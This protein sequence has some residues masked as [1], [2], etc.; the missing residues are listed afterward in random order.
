MTKYVAQKGEAGSAYWKEQAAI[1]NREFVDKLGKDTPVASITKADIRNLIERKA[2][3]LPGAARNLFAAIRPFFKW[4]V[5]RD[6][7]MV[8]SPVAALATPRAPKARDRILTDA[9]VIAFW[10]A[11]VEIGTLVGDHPLSTP[12]PIFTPFYQLLLLTAQRREEVAG[13]RWSE[14]DL[15]EATWTLP[16]ERTKNGKMHTVHLSAQALAITQALPRIS[17]YVLT[18]TGNSGVSGYSKAKQRLD[19][20]MQP[21]T[22]WVVHDLR[23]TAASG[24]AK[25]GFQPHIIERVLNHVSGAQGGLVGVYQRY[26]YLDERKRA[27]EAWGSYVEA[28]VSGRPQAENVVPLRA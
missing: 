25:L 9:E 22:P 5:S 17:D 26:E 19:G 16:K 11:T 23:R 18:T 10:K 6:D 4:Y 12:S 3:T 21:K 2:E 14:L 28:L 8:A 15:E 27:I 20:L 1:L 24:M 7:D 13:M